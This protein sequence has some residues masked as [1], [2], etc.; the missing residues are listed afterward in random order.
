MRMKRYVLWLLVCLLGGLMACSDDKNNEPSVQ[1]PVITVE[2][3]S[4]QVVFETAGG[5]QSVHFSTNVAWTA[6]TDQ[7]W[8]RVSPA[9]G[10]AGNVSVTVTLD[11]NETPDERNATL[12]LTAGTAVK[13]MTL[14]QKQKDALAVTSNKV[15]V[16]AEGGD[17]EIEVR[18]NV[19]FDYEIDETARAWV[20]PVETKA[21]TTTRLH[22]QVQP[23]EDREKREGKIVLRSGELSETV[24]VYQAAATPTIVLTQNEYTIGSDGEEI[25]IEL[26]S[27]VDYE[28]V[29][30]Q[31]ADWLNEVATR[32]FSSYTHRIQVAPNEDYDLREADIHFVSEAEGLDEVVHV[33]QVQ[34][35]A[36]LV[37]RQSYTVDA[38]AGQLDFV[39]NTN[40]EFQVSVSADWLKLVPD[41]RGLVEVPLSFTY[42]ANE[43]P[44]AREA[45]V[46]LSAEGVEQT[47]KVVQKGLQAPSRVSIVH[48]GSSFTAP[49]VT[50]AYFE[51]AFIS[52]GDGLREEYVEGASHVYE[53]ENAHTIVIES[54]GAEK[55]TLSGLV[56]VSSI[57]LTSF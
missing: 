32:A 38:E 13:R 11:E 24:T 2:G 4:T 28:M 8:C 41:T 51:D 53:D 30:P 48:V 20:T 34:K 49:L 45:L 23:N 52:W 31:D 18:A 36:I 37:A 47:V 14:V 35:D 19:S 12:V 46:T 50:G 3:E 10:S 27:N 33:V 39:V 5:S 56:G 21:L 43:G 9:S 25:V 29:L 17:F 54:M 26:R 1:T 55:I 6:E 7:D 44:V 15:E 22:F 57:D 42:D 40:V 16:G